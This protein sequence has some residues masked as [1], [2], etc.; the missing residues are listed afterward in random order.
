M[1]PY[2]LAENRFIV[3]AWLL[4]TVIRE[5][6]VLMVVTIAAVEAV[7]GVEE[8]LNADL[9]LAFILELVILTLFLH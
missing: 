4:M 9:A 8:G 5:I 1:G 3:S 2:L 7:L 6:K